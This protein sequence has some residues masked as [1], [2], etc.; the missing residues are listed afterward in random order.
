M[1]EMYGRM[2]N[3]LILFLLWLISVLLS[4]SFYSHERFTALFLNVF[5]LAQSVEFLFASLIFF[6][7]RIHWRPAYHCIGSNASVRCFC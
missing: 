7:S 3:V 5:A 4:I 6:L 2:P 1:I